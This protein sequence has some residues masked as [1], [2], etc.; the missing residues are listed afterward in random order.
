MN[1]L[2]QQVVFTVSHVRL[3]ACYT[4]ADNGKDLACP[5]EQFA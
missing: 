1:H 4:M 3:A 5:S 2:P